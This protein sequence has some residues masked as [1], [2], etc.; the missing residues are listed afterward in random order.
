M[1]VIAT[2]TEGK[3]TRVVEGF[4]LWA[5]DKQSHFIV[6]LYVLVDMSTFVFQEAV[7]LSPF[8]RC[9]F[10]PQRT[11]MRFFS[12]RA[13]HNCLFFLEIIEYLFIV[14]NDKIQSQNAKV[15]E[16]DQL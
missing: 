3:Q 15:M 9:K 11:V 4:C 14:V 10:I 6:Y 1:Q 16:K 12:V 13:S 7:K 5:L 2:K 8:V